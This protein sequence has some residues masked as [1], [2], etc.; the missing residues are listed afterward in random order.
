MKTKK[1]GKEGRV[2]NRQRFRRRDGKEK[3]L[4]MKKQMEVTLWVTG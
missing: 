3:E 1:R 4:K 2:E